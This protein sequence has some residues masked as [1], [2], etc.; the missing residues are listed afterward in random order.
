MNRKKIIKYLSILYF[1]ILLSLIISLLTCNAYPQR[2]NNLSI[3]KSFNHSNSGFHSALRSTRSTITPH[4]SGTGTSSD[5]YV[6]YDAADFDSI[7][8]IGLNNKYYVL[9]N[10]IDFSSI[11]E[12]APIPNDNTSGTFSLDGNGYIISNIKQTQ[13]VYTSTTTAYTLGIFVGKTAGS[14]KVKNIVLDGI[15]IIKTSVTNTSAIVFSASILAS[16]FSNTEIQLSNITVKN[17]TI[18]FTNSSA[19]FPSLSYVGLIVARANA[20]SVAGKQSFLRYCLVEYDTIHYYSTSTGHYVGGIAGI[21]PDGGVTIPFEYNAARYNYFYSRTTVPTRKNVGG[22]LIGVITSTSSAFNYNY[23]HSNVADFGN[24]G[25][26]NNHPW[27]WGGIFGY[28]G[29]NNIH[30]FHQNYAA[31]NQCIGVNQSGGF[32]S[33]DNSSSTAQ[34]IDSTYNFCDI[35]SFTEPNSVY[36]SV[37]LV[38]SQHPSPKTSSQLKDINTFIGWDFTNTWSID[39][40]LNS[41]FPYLK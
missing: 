14:F 11:Q 36:G 33:E 3:I 28:T 32:Y 15:K 16:Y 30:T 41:G 40:T 31:N 12:F 6:L 1:V 17:S 7:R 9:G 19:T 25:S 8:F 18:Y 13:G 37:R 21:L 34:F 2:L 10:D 20:T 24:G 22:G 5:P 23:S 39:S 4:I 38:A 27:G 26:P 29:V 35:I